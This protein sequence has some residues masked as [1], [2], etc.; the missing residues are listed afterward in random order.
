MSAVNTVLTVMLLYGVIAFV[1]S[2][3]ATYL[4]HSDGH[5]DRDFVFN[6]TMSS[7]LW[8]VI[9][10]A[11]LGMT[12]VDVAGPYARRARAYIISVLRRPYEEMAA[13]GAKAHA[14]EL[15]KEYAVEG[16]VPGSTPRDAFGE[17]RRQ[18]Q[19]WVRAHSH[20]T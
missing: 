11:I 14:R 15:A 12:V 18:G 9:I 17:L 10:I 2:L 5:P 1:V 20:E 6:V 3:V 19:A 7:I 16:P 4:E 13:A 8:P